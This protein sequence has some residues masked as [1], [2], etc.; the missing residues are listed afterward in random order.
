MSELEAA[1]LRLHAADAGRR[2]RLG[3][4]RSPRLP[5]RRAGPRLAADHPLAR[6]PPL[7]RTSHAT[8]NACRDALADAGVGTAVALPAGAHRSSRPT[9]R[10]PAPAAPNAEAL[11][12]VVRVAAVLPRADRRRG[13]HRRHDVVRRRIGSAPPSLPHG[14]VL[15]GPPVHLRVLPLLQRRARRSRRWCATCRRARAS[16]VDD[17]EIIVV[18]DGSSDGSAEVLDGADRRAR[19][20]ASSRTSVNRGYGGALISGFAAA[21]KDWVFYTDGD[22]QYDAKESTDLVEAGDRPTIDLVQ[23]VQDRPRRPVHRRDHR[24]H[25]PPRGASSR[26]V[27]TVR[28][29]D[30]D[31]RL[32]R[33]TLVVPAAASARAG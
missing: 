11:G 32:F 15:H 19:P 2:Q 31:F 23:G 14:S 5:R 12:G 26:S 24:P 27:C 6:A 22:A 1:W 17:F 10:S 21:T 30:C 9:A 28:D 3:G 20:R 33:R 4:G 13:A 29:T 16:C 7:R 25:L 18:D 8:V